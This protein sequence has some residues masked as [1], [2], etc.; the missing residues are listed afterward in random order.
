VGK[1]SEITTALDYAHR[2]ALDS[3]VLAAA[4]LLAAVH[5]EIRAASITTL[6][7]E[8]ARRRLRVLSGSIRDLASQVCELLDRR[9][10]RLDPE[11]CPHCAWPRAYETK[12]DCPRCGRARGALRKPSR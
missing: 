11:R 2:S 5:D 9:A 12:D 7:D 10:L 4:Q 6:S 8:L 3:K 1:L